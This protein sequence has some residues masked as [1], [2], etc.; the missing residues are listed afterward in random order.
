[1]L[2]LGVFVSGKPGSENGHS[3]ISTRPFLWISEGFSSG[4][5][6]EVI[7]FPGGTLGDL[8]TFLVGL[9]VTSGSGQ[10]GS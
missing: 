2:F 5:Q 3:S 8:G 10:G 1:M 4:S 7:W 9:L 6:T